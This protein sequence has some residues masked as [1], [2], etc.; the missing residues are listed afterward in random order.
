MPLREINPSR[1]SRRHVKDLEATRNLLLVTYPELTLEKDCVIHY[2]PYFYDRIIVD[3]RSFRLTKSMS[4]ESLSNYYLSARSAIEAISVYLPQANEKFNSCLAQFLQL[5]ESR[6]FDI[7]YTTFGGT[8]SFEDHLY[9]HFKM[10]Q[11]DFTY[12]ISQ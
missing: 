7:S 2:K 1:P 11:F 10:G 9:M 3:K 4:V 8:H 12:S 5:C 6:S